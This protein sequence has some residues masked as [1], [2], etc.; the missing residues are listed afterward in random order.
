MIETTRPW[1]AYQIIRHDESENFLVK[2]IV[3]KPNCRLSLQSHKHRSEHWVV[4]QGSG[5]V[6]LG[7]DELVCALNTHVFVPRGA[8]HRIHNTSQSTDLV[9]VEVQV[10]NILQEKGIV[11]YQD[12]YARI[13]PFDG[14]TVCVSGYFDP[15]HAGHLKYL[16]DAKK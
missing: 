14:K 2:K 1:G 11:R 7:E 15:V 16:K 12:D 8:K 3:V 5:K 9:F 10:G 4:V 13:S 6:V